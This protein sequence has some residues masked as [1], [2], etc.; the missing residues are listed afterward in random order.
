M[1]ILTFILNLVFSV[2]SAFFVLISVPSGAVFSFF[3]CCDTWQCSE[4]THTCSACGV[5]TEAIV[6]LVLE[7]KRLTRMQDVQGCSS[8]GINKSMSRNPVDKERKQV[9]RCECWLC[10]RI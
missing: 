5:E 7:S 9:C 10:L 4:S 3:F 8:A 2:K 6:Y 1:P